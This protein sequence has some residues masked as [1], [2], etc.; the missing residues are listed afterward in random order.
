MNKLAYSAM[1]ALFYGAGNTF[2][3][4]SCHKINAKGNGQLADPLPGDAEDIFRT[5]ASIQGGGLLQGTT[6]ASFTFT[7]T[8]LPLFQF[9]GE[10]TF[11]T[12]N[13]ATL[14][15]PLDGATFDPVTGSF[16]SEGIVEEGEATGR[17]EGASG[18]LVLEG[19]QD[20]SDPAGSF[21]EEISGEIC[22]DL[23]P[24]RG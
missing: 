8:S 15:L 6:K 20:L 10:L 14:T 1:A 5:E 21:T 19:I 2:A 9:S 18:K 23:G 16:Y 12:V 11:F 3:R 22:V 17:L 13:G 4:E 7:S 24:L